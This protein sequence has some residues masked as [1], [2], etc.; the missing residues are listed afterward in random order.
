MCGPGHGKAHALSQ[1]RSLSG[2]FRTGFFSGWSEA[3]QM[4][5]QGPAAPRWKQGL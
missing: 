1:T 5:S 4:W 2:A 3:E